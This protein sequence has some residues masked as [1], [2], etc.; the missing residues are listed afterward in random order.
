MAKWFQTVAAGLGAAMSYLYG[1]WSTL[2]EVLVAFVIVDYLTGILAAGVEGKLNSFTGFK[3]I[4][5]KI[6]IFVLVA[7]AYMLDRAQGEGTMFRDA[8]IW[9]YMANELLSIIENVGRAGLPVPNII[10]R[11]VEV[12]KGKGEGEAS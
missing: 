3:G 4:A 7:V 12:L 1:G 8:V 5:K 11:A 6:M 2:L 9:F 10:K